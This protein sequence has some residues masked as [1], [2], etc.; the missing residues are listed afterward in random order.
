MSNAVVDLFQN[1]D[2]LLAAL[3]AFG[4]A[5]LIQSLRSKARGDIPKDQHTEILD[6]L[7]EEKAKSVRLEER[8]MNLETNISAANAELESS[9]EE[10]K[11]LNRKLAAADERSEYLEKRISE[12]KEELERIHK[13]L[14]TEFE[15]LANRILD[16]KS[17][18]FVLQNK[19]SLDKLLT[20]LGE[21]IVSFRE[22]V[23]KTREEDLKDRA[24]LAE[25]IKAMSQLNQKMSEEARNLTTAL[26]GQ[27]KAQGNWG[28]IILERVLEKSGLVVGQEYETQA[29]LTDDEGRRFQPDVL[30]KLPEGKHLVVDSKVSLIAY[31]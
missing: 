3:V 4:I 30:I 2:W 6:T 28:E 15:N 29:S 9:R 22:R 20:P 27:S 1:W 25:Q 5:W 26:K 31:E 18:K 17:K 11:Q 16:E 23:E 14:T 13:K 10:T 24:S 8:T 19:E 21:K 7:E 12:Q